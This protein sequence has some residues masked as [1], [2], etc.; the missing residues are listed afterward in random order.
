MNKKYWLYV[1]FAQFIVLILARNFLSYSTFGTIANS[2]IYNA[3][4]AV[5]VISGLFAVKSYGIANMRG[6]MFFYIT[7]GI[8]LWSLGDILFDFFKFYLKIEAFPSLIDIIYLTGYPIFFIGLLKE[9][10]FASI[11]WSQKKKYLFFASSLMLIFLSSYSIM[12]LSYSSENNLMENL[13]NFLYGVG[14]IF[15][16][17]ILIFNLFIAIEYKKGSFFAPWL[18][19]FI[20]VFFIYFADILFGIYFQEYAAN[21]R[22]ARNLDL[23]YAAGYLFFAYGFFSFSQIVNK[24]RVKINPF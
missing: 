23:I 20:G 16:A 22:I 4:S 21:T 24:L 7:V 2:V 3:T 12:F 18:Y 10:D 6:K 1:L 11:N 9:R 15:L 17:I 13:F 19:F 8:F 14:D 5:A